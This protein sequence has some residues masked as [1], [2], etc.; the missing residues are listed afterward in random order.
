MTI[1]F[2]Y[3]KNPIY[4]DNHIRETIGPPPVDI[5]EAVTNPDLV[6]AIK[7][8]SSDNSDEAKDLVLAELNKS[9]FLAAILT[10]EMHSSEPDKDSKTTIE[11]DSIIKII[12]AADSD[13]NEYL[14]LFTDWNQISKYCK[15]PVNSLVLPA[16]DAWDWAVKMGKY[17]G[18]VVNPAENALP[19]NV[20]QIKYLRAQFPN[21]ES[22]D[23]A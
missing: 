11:K 17:A 19:L 6:A 10:D 2:L 14:P 9:N 18:V 21:K 4:M 13:G 23:D 12:S 22:S 1:Q 16:P 8:L 5:K 15:Q 3:L 7:A 20:G